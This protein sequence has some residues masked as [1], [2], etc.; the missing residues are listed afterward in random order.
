VRR[1]GRFRQT[2]HVSERK[3]LLAFVDL[4][5]L[6]LALLAVLH[7]RLG[8]PFGVVTVVNRPGWFV[9]FSLTWVVAAVLTEA[10]DLRTAARLPQAVIRAWTAALLGDA[11]YLAIPYWTPYLLPS[12]LTVL[13][14]LALTLGGVGT[15]RLLYA[16]IFVQPSFRHPV[17]ILGAGPVGREILEVM[18]THGA[19]EY[20]P[21]GFVDDLPSVGRHIDGLQVLGARRELVRVL[22]RAGASEVVVAL[23]PAEGTAGALFQTLADCAERGISVTPMHR[24]VEMLTGQVPV[25]HAGRNLSVVL[26]LDRTPPVV[27]D[28]LKR[29]TDIALALV[30]VI[31]M[32]AIIPV[33]IVGVWVEARGP[34]FYRQ[35]RVGQG[36][37]EFELIKFRTMVTG[38]EPE[39]PRWAALHDPRVTRVGRLLRRLHLDELPQAL[40]ILSGEMSVIGPRPERPDFVAELERVIP[41]YRIRLSVRPGVTG[42]AQVNYEYGDSAEDA[43]V[44][45][46]YDLYY[47]KYRSVA[48]DLSI[49]ARTLTH[50]LRLAGR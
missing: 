40:N 14:L 12:R 7:H 39:G 45:L 32:L 6:N 23:P 33:A 36:G 15:W 19:T 3:V 13:A 17:V 29:M 42:W 27:F 11:L 38:A 9:L 43:L 24:V 31:G 34:I 46:R 10:Y 5:C 20:L 26:P 35:R 41:F 48:L 47:I 18:R 8:F 44:K 49:L 1:L 16:V 4:L 28:A 21:V 2:L 50:V 25:E 30:G 22:E 37:R